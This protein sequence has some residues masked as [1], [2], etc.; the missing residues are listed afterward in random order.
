M[1]DL[2]WRDGEN[3]HIDYRWTAG[4][5]ARFLTA[6]AELVGLKPNVILADATPSVTAL[7]HKTQTIPIVFITVND[8]IGSGFVQSLARP[9]GMITGFTNFAQRARHPYHGRVRSECHV[10]ASMQSAQQGWSRHRPRCSPPCAPDSMTPVPS[11]T[12]GPAT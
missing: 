4:V 8:P 5:N 6:A 12:E 9:G 2:G 11:D 3:V 10:E 7:A 1:H